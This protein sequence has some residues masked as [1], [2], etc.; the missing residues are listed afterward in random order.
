[1]P[2]NP[3]TLTLTGPSSSVDPASKLA[4]WF[5]DTA[6]RPFNI[7][8]GM[9][10]TGSTASVYSIQHTFDYVGGKGRTK[11]KAHGGHTDVYIT[12]GG[13]HEWT[14]EDNRREGRAEGGG[15]WIKGAIRHPGSLRKS[16]G[17]K[18]GEDIPE[19]KLTKAEHSDNPK[20]ARRARLAETL[21]GLH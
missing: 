15:N 4:L 1:M 18:E 8:I 13:K 2:S 3:V 16:L 19:K 7:G 6:V 14:D 12:K 17:V 5:P 11:K 20:T 9:D 21:K 10:A